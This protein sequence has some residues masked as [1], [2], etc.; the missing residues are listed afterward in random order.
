MFVHLIFNKSVNSHIQWINKHEPLS[1]TGFI[2]AVLLAG[3]SV[4]QLLWWNVCLL[5]NINKLSPHFVSLTHSILNLLILSLPFPRHLTTRLAAPAGLSHVYTVH[6]HT[7]PDFQCP[8]VA[9]DLVPLRNAPYQYKYTLEKCSSLCACCCCVFKGFKLP[10]LNVI[11]LK[12]CL[13]GLALRVD[14]F[15]HARS[16]SVCSFSKS[17]INAQYSLRIGIED[18]LECV[19]GVNNEIMFFTNYLSLACYLWLWTVLWLSLCK[20][21]IC[22]NQK[23]LQRPLL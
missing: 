10:S 21:F 3:L 20:F 7:D 23:S 8:S 11:S 1:R 9:S 15:Y 18:P 14:T 12:A 2:S 4:S 5:M 16:R 19:M 13:K 22:W 6:T 17:L